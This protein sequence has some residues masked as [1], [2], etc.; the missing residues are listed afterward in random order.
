MLD[1]YSSKT[2]LTVEPDAELSDSASSASTG[3]VAKRKGTILASSNNANPKRS[4]FEY[5]KEIMSDI[6]LMFEDYAVG[7]SRG[8]V[9]PRLFYQSE[10]NGGDISTLDQ[11][12]MFDCVSE[13]LDLRCK[14]YVGGGYRSLAKG[15]S[16]VRRKDIL[17]QEVYR[18]ISSWNANIGDSMIDELVDKDMSNQY[19]R[20]LDFD[21]EVFELGTQIQSRILNS[22]IDEVIADIVML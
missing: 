10:S 3:A 20:W 19:G 16:L 4:D 18:E 21:I 9:N 6:E 1:S 15:I 11:R 7:R 17:A 12:I 13:C 5:V 2:Y 22:L 8:V 14:Q